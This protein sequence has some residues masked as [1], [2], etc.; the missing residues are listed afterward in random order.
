MRQL[1]RFVGRCG[2]DERSFT[3]TQIMKY[4]R[5]HDH[6]SL[7]SLVRSAPDFANTTL[8]DG[9]LIAESEPQPAAAKGA[10]A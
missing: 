3:E 6:E 7:R 2:R 1:N 5:H 10:R 4:T 9:D 8:S